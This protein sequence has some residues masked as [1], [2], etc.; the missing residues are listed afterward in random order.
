MSKRWVIVPLA[1]V[2]AIVGWCGSAAAF[3]PFDGTDAAVV[4]TGKAEIEFGPVEYRRE[5]AARTL[6][7]PSARIN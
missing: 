6:F 4:E 2:I 7:A 3:R 1:S 5:A